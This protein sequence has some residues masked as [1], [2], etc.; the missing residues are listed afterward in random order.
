MHELRQ[1]TEK[2]KELAD[3]LGINTI[4]KSFRVLSAEI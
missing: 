1:P 2:Q 3:S 4:E